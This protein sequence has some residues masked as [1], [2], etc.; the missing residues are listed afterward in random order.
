[1]RTLESV[2]PRN[3]PSVAGAAVEWNEATV[4][5]ANTLLGHCLEEESTFRA[6]LLLLAI[7]IWGIDKNLTTG[8]VG[9]SVYR[10]VRD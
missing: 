7:M 1:M 2:R 10:L 9:A 5:R 6:T 4:E 3:T 8:E